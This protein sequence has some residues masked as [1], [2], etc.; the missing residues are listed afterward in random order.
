[1]KIVFNKDRALQALKTFNWLNL[2]NNKEFKLKS[3]QIIVATLIAYNGAT[4]K[5]FFKRAIPGKSIDDVIKVLLDAHI[6][7]C[8]DENA[9]N[10]QYTLNVEPDIEVDV[11]ESA[12]YI[13]TNCLFNLDKYVTTYDIKSWNVLSS[14]IEIPQFL[15]VSNETF[16]YS[17]K[18]MNAAGGSICNRREIRE[19]LEK[20]GVMKLV[21]QRTRGKE[22]SK[23]RL[24]KKAYLMGA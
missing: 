11:S 14:M 18:D 4:T 8:V 2:N 24:N 6:I 1:M 10:K 21:G 15:T 20:I 16:N 9:K 19:Q 7:R 13:F 17:L 5:S 12:L 22:N 3:K 23:F